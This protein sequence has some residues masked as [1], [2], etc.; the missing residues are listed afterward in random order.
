MMLIS[1]PVCVPNRAPITT[2][3]INKVGDAFWKGGSAMLCTASRDMIRNIEQC[4][5]M[6]TTHQP[7]QS[8]YV[9]TINPDVDIFFQ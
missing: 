7:R 6:P 3:H 2:H 4:E 8:V 1:L 9:W 5:R